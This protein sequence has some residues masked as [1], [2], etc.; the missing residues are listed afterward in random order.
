MAISL[1]FF[2]LWPGHRVLHACCNEVP[3]SSTEELA[4]PERQGAR[5]ASVSD[6]FPDFGRKIA[7]FRRLKN[8]SEG[9]L[10]GRARRRVISEEPAD[11]RAEDSRQVCGQPCETCDEETHQ[12]KDRLLVGDRGA[13]LNAAALEKRSVALQFPW[14]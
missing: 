3:F 12:W 2:G 9:G 13:D 7:A 1:G 11:V 4:S 14:G 8:A 6:G 5:F 10:R